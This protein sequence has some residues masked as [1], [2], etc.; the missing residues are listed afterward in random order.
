MVDDH[1]RLVDQ[2]KLMVAKYNRDVQQYNGLLSRFQADSKTYDDKI[3]HYNAQVNEGNG[4]ARTIGTTW[5]IVPV[6][7]GGAHGHVTSPARR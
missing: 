2:Q 4:V 7:R 3:E 6:P 1:N 5:F